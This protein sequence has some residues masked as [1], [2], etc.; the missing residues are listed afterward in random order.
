MGRA[1]KQLSSLL[2]CLALLFAGT[3]M[4][5]GQSNADIL[6]RLDRAAHSF[7]AAT[8]NIRVTTHTAIIDEDDT[9]IGT[10][11][12]KRY[13]PT[14]MHFLI[15]F[16]GPDAQAL[17]F[18]GQTLQIY[19]PKLNTVREYDIGK[20]KDLAQKLILLGFGM[21]GRE[22]NANYHITN[23]GNEQVQDQDSVRLQLTPK[24]SEVLKQL[25][26]VDLWLSLK[27]HCPV[28]QKFYLP[29]GD[30]RLVTYSDVEIKPHLPESALDLPKAAKHERVN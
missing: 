26:K 29:G 4:C 6:S 23:F 13:S 19:Y 24:A 8:A 14:E 30:Y 10:V 21:T 5:R 7:S 20:Y 12:V 9:Q 11:A 2:Q 16:S 3:T 1:S 25:S 15:T 22:L 27:N 17:A 18:R 28:Q